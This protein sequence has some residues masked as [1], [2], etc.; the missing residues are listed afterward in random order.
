MAETI[1]QPKV[2]DPDRVPEIVCDGPL[3]IHWLGNRGTITF[4]HPRA[5]AEPLFEGSEVPLDLVVRA[6]IA[7]SIENLIALRDLLAQ[8]VPAD[9]PAVETPAGGGATGKLH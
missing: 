8:L 2:G 9:K 1:P 5:K 3:N 7:T 4:T 6:R